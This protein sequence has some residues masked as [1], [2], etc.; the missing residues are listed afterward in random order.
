LAYIAISRGGMTRV[1]SFPP[2]VSER[3]R[4]LIL[5]SMPGE[6]S[7]KAGQYYAHPRNAFWHI[8][9]ELFGAG[10]S[11]PYQERVALVQSVGIALWDTL[12]VCTRPGSLDVSIT[13]EVANDFPTFFARY[14]NIT[15][16]F[17]NGTKPERAFR[18][19]SRPAL[20]DDRHIFV[21]LPSTSPANA[22]MPL[23]AKV[24]AWSIL[25]KVPS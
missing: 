6:L 8:M 10:P 16:V 4:L 22:A 9:G 11:L 23:E 3:S 21:R 20:Q 14:A 24:K 12:Q 18:R 19:H 17:F 15:H 7:L 25:K 13:E 2:I 1:K 5:G